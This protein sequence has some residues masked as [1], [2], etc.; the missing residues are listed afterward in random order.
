MFA[1]AGPQLGAVFTLEGAC[2]LIGH[3]RGMAVSLDDDT[4][5]SRHASL[6]LS[7]DG[8]S[9]ED[10]GSR[11]GTFVNDRRIAG[12]WPLLDGDHV[13]FGSATILKFSML[14]DLEEH[15]LTTLFSLTLRDPLTRLYN[16]RYFDDRV[17]S[18]VSFARRQRTLVALLLIDID[19][20][21][22]INDTC[23]H[24]LGDAVLKL[25]A[26]SIER[27]MRPEDVLSRFGGDEFVIIARATSL[28][29]LEIL[30][31]RICQRVAAL[32]PSLPKLEQGVTVSVGVALLGPD[33]TVASSETLIA[34]AD[35]A[36]YRAKAAGRNRA[37]VC[38]VTSDVSGSE[39]PPARRTQPP[40]A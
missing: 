25:T 35:Q 11:N 36:L 6:T 7:S 4:V 8:A 30:A 14:D 38:A 39:G 31:Q 26:S 23:G 29:N 2:V 17:R 1:L 22:S 12:P 33:A 34:A 24:Q 40:Q 15:A 28:R 18:E 16:R 19:R 20:F 27:I 37:V 32:S 13:R 5:S 10:L 3:D 9:I 21:K